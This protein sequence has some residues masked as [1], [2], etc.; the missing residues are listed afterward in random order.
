[1]IVR[2][3][4]PFL[5]VATLAC[6]LSP[7]LSWAQTWTRSTDNPNKTVLTLRWINPL[8]EATSLPLKQAQIDALPLHSISLQLPMALGIEGFHQWRGISLQDLLKLADS[9]GEH[10]RIQALNGYYTVMP[11]SDV[12][13]YNPVLANHRDGIKLS[14][15]DKGPFILIYPFQQY[16]ELNQ[17]TYMNRSVWQINEIHI[18]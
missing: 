5:A 3:R 2:V 18:E 1:M 7:L 10:L 14:I 8:G 16:D 11:R 4:L 12:A 13:R 15:R 17:Q 9:P 6:V